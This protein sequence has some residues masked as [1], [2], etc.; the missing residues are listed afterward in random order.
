V[1]ISLRNHARGRVQEQV[2]PV[3]HPKEVVMHRSISSWQILATTLAAA[4][5]VTPGGCG[6]EGAAPPQPEEL[7]E[8][9]LPLT[10][11]AND[12]TYRL[13]NVFIAISG[14]QYTQLFDGGDPNQTALS[15]TLTTGNYQA[16]LYG[17]WG[18]ERDDGTGNFLPV[19][20]SLASSPAIGFTIF[21]G[22]TSTVSY[23]FQTDGVIVTVGSGG[24][25]VTAT[26]SEVGAA[27]TPF[28]TDCGEGA[29]CPPTTLTGAAR[30][31]IPAGATPL[32]S[33]CATPTEC[34]ANASCFDLGA[35]PVCAALCP[36]TQFDGPCDAGGTCQAIGAEY[37]VCRPVEADPTP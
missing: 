14:P 24:L 20:A 7:G 22:A 29:W 6:V 26:V 9:S 11:Q 1:T 2:D 3:N 25:R 13:R 15:A 10:T 27:C 34:V 17:G 16:F 8:I 4:A 18:L 37:G 28:G 36:S 19:M 33:S 5:A 35:G 30:A 32:G 12:H 31:C 21:N 23:Q